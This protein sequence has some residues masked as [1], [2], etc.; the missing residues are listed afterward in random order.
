MNLHE[1]RELFADAVTITAQHMNLP[2]I[3]VEKD[4]WV[5]LALQR[6]FMSPLAE[7]AIFKGGTAL[8]KCFSFIHRFSEDIDLV[9]LKEPH[10]SANQLKERLK[11]ISNVVAEFLP[12]IDVIGMTNKKGMIRKTAHSY[13]RVFAGDFGQVRDLIILES[14][15]L[16]SSEPV[17]KGQVSSF[18]YQMM[19]ARKQDELA[20]QY[21]LM[22]FEVVLLAPTRT[23]CEKIMSLVR[24]SY[25]EKPLVDLRNKIRHVYDLHQLLK[26]DD[27]AA[28]FNSDAFVV[29]LHKVGRD[30]EVSFRNNKDWLYRHPLQALLFAELDRV[31]PELRGTYNGSFKNLVFGKLPADEAV[32][33][34]LQRIKERLALVAWNLEL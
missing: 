16:G 13:S 31:W 18:I 20:I 28:F 6:I 33:Q 3:Y 19:Q 14:S 2:E 17:I 29:M 24:F 30:D 1:N 10:L 22:P 34:T 21:D 9:L 5:T 4:Y 26:Q 7:F 12:E 27:L 25:T 32:F 11:R 15:W 8:A 23:L